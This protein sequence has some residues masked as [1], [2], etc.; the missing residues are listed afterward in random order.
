MLRK[1]NVTEY[2]V[3]PAATAATLLGPDAA[4]ELARLGPAA[5]A[6][7][8]VSDGGEPDYAAA[9]QFGAKQPPRGSAAKLL[10]SPPAPLRRV[11]DIGGVAIYQVRERQY[12][13]TRRT[14]R[15]SRRA[16]SR[17]R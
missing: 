7:T 6:L 5:V 10:P 1:P 8:G 11:G 16:S 12:Q 9:A 13:E 14:P 15:P 2:A 17:W 4:A 3:R